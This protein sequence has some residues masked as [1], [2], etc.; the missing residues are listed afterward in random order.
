M[1][2]AKDEA[3]GNIGIFHKYNDTK[4]NTIRLKLQY[5]NL[6]YTKKWTSM[7]STIAEN[8][9]QLMNSELSEF[10]SLLAR[11]DVQWVMKV[12]TFS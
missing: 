11:G 8:T 9:S 6:P 5:I 10:F 3:I 7:A 12:P 1:T 2:E 4:K